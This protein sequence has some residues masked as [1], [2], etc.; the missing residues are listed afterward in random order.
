MP[1][2][3]RQH[4]V[5]WL[6]ALASF[7]AFVLSMSYLYGRMDE[8]ISALE[9]EREADNAQWLAAR[10]RIERVIDAIEADIERQKATG[11]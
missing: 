3:F 9:R 8:R 5:A 10:A 1:E 7:I 2:T 4:R 11:R 6:T